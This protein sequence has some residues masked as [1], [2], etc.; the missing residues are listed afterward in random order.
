MLCYLQSLL[1]DFVVESKSMNHM[2]SPNHAT[3]CPT[4]K[5]ASMA[6]NA[7]MDPKYYRSVILLVLLYAGIR[8]AL[9]EARRRQVD[10]KQQ[11]RLRF[12]RGFQ[13]GVLHM[14]ADDEQQPDAWF[15]EL[16]REEEDQWNMNGQQQQGDGDREVGMQGVVD[17]QSL[18]EGKGGLQG[19]E[20]EEQQGVGEGVQGYANGS[21]NGAVGGGGGYMSRGFGDRAFRPSR[22][23]D[24]EEGKRGV[25][26]GPYEW[27]EGMEKG[28]D[29]GK[30]LGLGHRKKEKVEE[31]DGLEWEEEGDEEEWVE[32]EEEEEQ[33]EDWSNSKEGLG[34]ARWE[35]GMRL[36]EEEMKKKEAEE[37]ARAKAAAAEQAA[38]G[39][40]LA[41]AGASSSSGVV[42]RSAVADRAAVHSEGA[43]ATAPMTDAGTAAA[44]S[45]STAATAAAVSGYRA[46]EHDRA[47]A[48]EMTGTLADADDLEG[49]EG[50]AAELVWEEGEAQEEEEAAELNLQEADPRA[51]ARHLKTWFDLKPK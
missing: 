12:Q 16:E 5:L 9:S 1:F 24:V 51:L 14:P 46:A 29:Y 7:S 40:A 20:G 22:L 32:E 30:A 25:D 38:K 3:A 33:E 49:E 4:T 35:E 21:G 44:V 28:L 8:K 6:T 48:G 17:G 36:V 43:A 45:A 26:L 23:V 39:R 27:G 11:L 50:E 41:A 37:A 19:A 2:E 18:Q 15:E 47:P 42:A 10:S 31:G 34:G 13:R